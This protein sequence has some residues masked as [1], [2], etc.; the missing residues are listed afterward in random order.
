MSKK[1]KEKKESSDLGRYLMFAI[2]VIA[3]VAIVGV[4]AYKII[5]PSIVDEEDEVVD[6]NRVEIKG[7]GIYLDDNDSNLYK[8]EYEILEE[9]LLGDTINYEE[10]AKSVAKLFIIDL[11]TI[12]NKTNKYDVGGVDFLYP[13]SVENFTL[14][15]TD[16]I[17]KY[18][19][20]NTSGE[21]TQQLPAVNAISVSAIKEGTFEIKS[22]KKTY[23]SYVVNLNW[24]YSIDLGYDKEG[25]VIIINKD[26]KLYV[27]E[28][29]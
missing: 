24:T 8:K 7:Y 25:E 17:Y 4:L 28:K 1:G 3:V 16:T 5:G 2:V 11:Y 29:N 21:R 9:N 15:V 27:V 13:A 26:D 19:E 23:N 22:E 20:D 12:K 10:Y 14:N 6:L 18:V